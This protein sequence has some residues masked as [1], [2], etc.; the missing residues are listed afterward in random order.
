MLILQ[1]DYLRSRE[2]LRLT[3]RND[4]Q[5]GDNAHVAQGMEQYS[6]LETGVNLTNHKNCWKGLMTRR[7]Q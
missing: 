5:E 2:K 6:E 7:K 3:S 1:M 4:G